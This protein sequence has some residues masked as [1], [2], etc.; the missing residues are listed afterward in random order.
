MKAPLTVGLMIIIS[1]VNGYCVIDLILHLRHPPSDLASTRDERHRLE[2]KISHLQEQLE[3]SKRR[4]QASNEAYAELADKYHDMTEFNRTVVSNLPGSPQKQRKKGSQKQGK[5]GSTAKRPRGRA[6]KKKATTRSFISDGA[7]QPPSREG[8]SLS[9]SSHRAKSSSKNVYDR[10]KN[11]YGKD[12]PFLLGTNAGATHSLIGN[13]Q[14]SLGDKRACGYRAPP[15]P[16]RGTTRSRSNSSSHRSKQ[17]VHSIRS[18]VHEPSDWQE[19]AVSD[20]GEH[21]DSEVQENVE[22]ASPRLSTSERARK[23]RGNRRTLSPEVAYRSSEEVDKVIQALE[24]EY[25]TLED[26]YNNLM[27]RISDLKHKDS[28][29]QEARENEKLSN[30]LQ[31]LV[32]LMRAKGEQLELLKQMK[33]DIINSSER[34]PIRD[35]Q[36]TRRRSEAMRLFHQLRD[37]ASQS[38]PWLL[39]P[40]KLQSRHSH[41]GKQG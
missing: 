30:A 23:P 40:E 7:Q 24:N 39:H 20:G 5:N 9:S 36:A 25:Y 19:D 13:V 21:S 14:L 37:I 18:H 10:L 15:P 28:D 26:R 8:R 38:N 17:N 1:V 4:E 34:S 32:D 6:K 31:E 22:N 33:D 27:D 35:P 29:N 12:F 41:S 2:G 3:E 11:F 16:N